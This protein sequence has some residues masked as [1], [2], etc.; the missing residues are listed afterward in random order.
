VTFRVGLRRL[1]LLAGA[2]TVALI[3]AVF[4]AVADPV[5]PHLD[6]LPE[7]WPSAYTGVYR[8]AA[9]VYGVPWLLLAAIHAQESSSSA[10]R[11]DGIRGDAVSSGWNG[12]GAA[13]PMQFGIV[14]VP[15]YNA[16]APSCGALTG[17]GAGN[18]W[19][20]Y[21]DAFRRLPQ[22][23]RPA[24]YPQMRDRLASCA[25]VPNQHGCVYDDVDAIVAA[26]AYLHDLGAGPQLDDRAWHAARRYNGAA[27]YADAVLARARA[28]EAQLADDLTLTDPITIPGA[29]ARLGADGLAR[30]P[31]NAPRA[32]RRAI[33]AANAIS[34][35]PYLLRH[36]PTHIGN[37][38]YDCSSS[39]SHV[40]WGAGVFGTA[41]WVSGAFLR[42]GKPGPGRW[43]TVYANAGHMFLVVA[44]LRFDT[45]RYDT[46]PNAR[47]SGPRW[48][49]GPRPTS[50]FVVRHAPGL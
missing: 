6:R 36:Y 48:R 49:L 22:N 26:A 42:Y 47:E 9:G 2:A 38:T 34:D 24:R 30:A 37:P 11:I 8:G 1:A 4:G 15:P 33:A 14:G 40:L 3:A 46:G 27:A 35:R 13:G 18:T 32:V 31:E 44:G 5:A 39:S 21:R 25:N 12:C 19:A 23:A 45:S 28:W 17:T 10:L 7:A 50:N 41:P 16:T 29:R 20:R 43:I